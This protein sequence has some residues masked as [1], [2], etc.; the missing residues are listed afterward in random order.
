M[1]GQVRKVQV[2]RLTKK[3]L[4][5]PAATG[6]GQCADELSK[7]DDAVLVVV[8]DIEHKV[9]EVGGIAKR[10]E[11]LV[12]LLKLGLV[13]L[14]RRTVLQKSLVPNHHTQTHFLKGIGWLTLA[15]GL[16]LLKLLLVDFFFS[17]LVNSVRYKAITK[18]LA[19]YSR[20]AFA[21][22]PAARW[23]ACSAP[24]P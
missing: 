10:E 20:C 22:P 9:G 19:S 5:Y 12:Y 24:C 14:A 4:V 1:N 23:S 16:P 13:Q 2:T 18:G 6:D 21:N 11:L 17:A 7:V 8:K 15:L 3:L